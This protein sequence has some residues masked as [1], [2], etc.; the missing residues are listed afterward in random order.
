MIK[1]SEPVD[2]AQV[3]ARSPL[4]QGLPS[5]AIKQLES[6]ARVKQYALNSY[7]YSVGE[8]S[9]VVT[10]LEHYFIKD[11]DALVQETDLSEL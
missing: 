7:L 9:I 11:I 2:I 4:F 6:G 3:L 8:Q 1:A 5:D 10:Q